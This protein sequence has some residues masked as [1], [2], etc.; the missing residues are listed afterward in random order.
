V[1]NKKEPFIYDKTL[2]EILQGI[3][4]KFIQIL[5][6]KKAVEILDSSFPK[7]EEREADLIVKLE[8][9][10]I[11]HLEI[12]TATDTSM[13]KRML[14]YASL[15]YDLYDIFPLQ[16]VLYI[17]DHDTKMSGKIKNSSLQYSYTVKKMRDI[18]CRQLIESE[19]I[20][21]N[22]LAVLC[23]IDDFDKF[24][25]KLQQKLMN[26]DNKKR[27]DYLRKLAYILRL[28]PKLYD[29]IYAKQK[30]ELAMPF[31]LHKRIDPLYKAG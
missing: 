1:E 28:R 11:F 2:R 14:K 25:F 7:V 23:K 4:Q 24:I 3:P 9:G 21:D 30:K 6:N 17:G 27:E 22:I 19:D 20:G 18:D 5:I 8:D 31:V 16:M 13:P 12:Q 15:I 10:S 29:K 26:L